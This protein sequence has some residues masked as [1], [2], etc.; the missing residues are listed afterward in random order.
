MPPTVTIEAR[1]RIVELCI[2]GVSQREICQRT[3]R[4]LKAENRIIRAYRDNGRLTDDQRIGRPRSTDEEADRLI[5]ACV[6]ADPFVSA[7]DIRSELNLNIS[8][9]TIR[10][11]LR[12]A[13]LK[14]CV[15]AQK[16]HL[17]ERQRRPRLEFA[18]AVQG[19]TVDDRREVIFSDE[20]TFSSR[21]DQQRRVWRPFNCR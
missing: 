6:V 19:W 14:N 8:C 18:R 12:E 13:G 21:W 15:A 11:R 3:G 20:S 2:H 1:K 9:S 4:P 10:R 5:I 7:K 16:P 17:T